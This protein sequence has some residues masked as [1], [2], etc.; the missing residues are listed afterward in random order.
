MSEVEWRSNKMRYEVPSDAPTAQDTLAD[1]RASGTRPKIIEMYSSSYNE[2]SNSEDKKNLQR[3]VFLVGC[4][5]LP[6]ADLQSV[7]GI[8]SHGLQIRASV[9]INAN[10][11]ERVKLTPNL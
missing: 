5:I 4:C 3:E 11:R 10:P 6:V 1:G 8:R 2:L 7:T 9:G